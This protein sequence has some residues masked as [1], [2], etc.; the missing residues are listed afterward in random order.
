VPPKAARPLASEGLA[1]TVAGR[2]ERLEKIADGGSGTLYRAIDLETGAELALKCFQMHRAFDAGLLPSLHEAQRLAAALGPKVLVPL[3]D[4]GTDEDG[5][6]YLAMPLLRGETLAS[7]MQRPLSVRDVRRIML[8][9]ERAIEAL[10]HAGFTHGDVSEENVFLVHDG[11]IVLLDHES[12]GRIGTPR[13]T[14]HTEG[15]P[16]LA[17]GLRHASDDA[18]A[19]QALSAALTRRTNPILSRYA[20]YMIATLALLGLIALLMSLISR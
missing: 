11:S 5:T 7:R 10:R 4:L 18:E 9:L 15:T 1:F 14:R 17:P 8:P 12:L 13:P 20:L 2:Y 19:L 6:P 3:L 16:D